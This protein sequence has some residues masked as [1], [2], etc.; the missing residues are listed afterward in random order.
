MPY[1]KTQMTESSKKSMGL[2]DLNSIGAKN[3]EILAMAR[4]ERLNKY[5]RVTG[6]KRKLSTTKLSGLS[7]L[8]S[9]PSMPDGYKRR[10]RNG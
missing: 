1:D 10:S 6:A 8:G 2:S 5:G 7:S 3:R 4:G 9:T